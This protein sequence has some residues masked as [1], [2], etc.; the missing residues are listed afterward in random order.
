MA[1]FLSFKDQLSFQLFGK[2]LTDALNEDICL[3]C[4]N[5]KGEFRDPLSERD[6]FISG[7]CQKCQDEIYENTEVLNDH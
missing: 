6:Y 1:G 3:R 2:T 4:K 5:P 7:M